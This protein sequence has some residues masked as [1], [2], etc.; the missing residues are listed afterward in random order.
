[1]IETARLILRPFRQSDLQSLAA[2]ITDIRTRRFLGGVVHADP[3]A[4]LDEEMETQART[5]IG[6]MPVVRE[7]DGEM[8]GYA[9]LRHIPYALP[10]TPAIDIGWVLAHGAQGHGYATE[11]ACGWLDHGFDAMQL[12]EIVAYTSAGNAASLAVMQRLG[13]RPDPARDFDHPRAL[14]EPDDIRR[15][16]VHAITRQAWTRSR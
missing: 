14:D 8:I 1:M 16:L 9:G 11:A 2:I 12:D 7:A 13:M 10:F 4:W 3:Q 6:F 5:G 15:Q